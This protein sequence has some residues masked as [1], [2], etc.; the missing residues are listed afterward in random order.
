MNRART[1][2]GVKV[3][4]RLT[5]VL[6]MVFVLLSAGKARAQLESLTLYDNFTAPKISPDKWI[7]GETRDF[8]GLKAHRGI[9]NGQLQL[10]TRSVGFTASDAGVGTNFVFL[11]HPDPEE[12]TE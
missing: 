3:F 1:V 5:V 12:V 10:T 8:L 9:S 6:S 2:D 4:P 11:A 7:G